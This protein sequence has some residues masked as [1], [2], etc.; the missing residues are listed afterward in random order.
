MATRKKTAVGRKKSASSRT[1]ERRPAANKKWSAQVMK[2]SDAMDLQKGVFKLS[3]GAAVARSLK[4]SAERSSR[5]KSP[6]FRSAMSMLN[7]EIN[8]GGKNLSATQLRIL[9]QAKLELRKLFG[10][11]PAPTASK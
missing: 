8:R 4:R 7:F 9:N 3:S 1:A 6:P 11:E 2:T 10:K 5:R